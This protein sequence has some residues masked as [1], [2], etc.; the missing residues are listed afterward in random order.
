[1]NISKIMGIEITSKKQA[2]EI[3]ENIEDTFPLEAIDYLYEHETDQEILDKIVYHLERAYQF[4]DEEE[5]SYAPLW[6]AIV[7]EGHPHI[8]LVKPVVGLFT[9]THDTGDFLDEQGSYLTS[10]LC[11]ELGDEAIEMFVSVIEEEIKKDSDFFIPFLFDCF[12]YVDQDKYY[13]RLLAMLDNKYYEHIDSLIGSFGQANFTRLLP[14]MK[15]IYQYYKEQDDE[16]EEEVY[17]RTAI[18]I[19]S[20]IK[21]IE[22]D[23]FRAKY[24]ESY[25]KTREH[26]KEHYSRWDQNQEEYR[27]SLKEEV[28]IKTEE[29]KRLI[30][31]LNA[32][33]KISAMQNI[34]RNDPCYC[35]SGKKY[36]KCCIE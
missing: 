10:K 20:G 15:E 23:V 19:E 14:R 7:A 2:F 9:K 25:Y 32:M 36:K 29:L 4:D 16:R 26:W 12:D 18:E 8:S 34:G 3:I 11:E 27:E 5:W 30:Q 1:M 22:L 21:M 35:G 28:R 33:K 13:D 6:Y 24:G 17:F 31:Q